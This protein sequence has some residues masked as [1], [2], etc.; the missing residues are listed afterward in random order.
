VTP[1]ILVDFPVVPSISGV[2][3][4]FRTTTSTTPVAMPGAIVDI[5]DE[6]GNWV[7]S[8]EAG[9]VGEYTIF[10]LGPGT[11]YLRADD[12]YGYYPKNPA[13]W[14]SESDWYG[15]CVYLAYE[16][17]SDKPDLAV[18]TPITVGSSNLTGYN[19]NLAYGA[20]IKGKVTATTAS[21]A[22]PSVVVCAY[23]TESDWYGDCVY[24]DDAG[25]YEIT[26]LPNGTYRLFFDATEADPGLSSAWLGASGAVSSYGSAATK[27]V[28]VKGLGLTAQNI[29]LM[30][31]FVTAPT[32]TIY[33]TA[34]FGQT[35]I[36]NEGSWLP[37]PTSFTYQWRRDGVPISG[38]TA[39][40]YVLQLADIGHPITVEVTGV[41]TNYLAEPQTSDPTGDVTAADYATAPTP[42]IT[43]NVNVA[44]VLTAVPGV[45]VPAPTGFTYQWRRDGGNISSATASTYTL[46][47]DDLGAQMSVVVS[48]VKSGFASTTRTSASSASVAAA[49]FT[50]A[51]VPT[52]MGTLKV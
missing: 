39:K 24:T 25:N 11:Y 13:C 5:Y 26:N 8:T 49:L 9:D 7:D 28:S 23:I 35:L 16:F 21:T 48:P 20:S 18:A 31:A 12:W 37:T 36:V 6:L 46:T 27:T 51:P 33:G 52:I 14:D 42:T 32:P 47:A 29:T 22:A 34:K 41:K 30:A 10:S 3:K 2:V 17:Y 19:I 40:T 44:K 1:A 43:G 45:W 38:A 50:T 4:Y 15:D